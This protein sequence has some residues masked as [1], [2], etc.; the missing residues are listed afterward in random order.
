MLQSASQPTALKDIAS[1]MCYSTVDEAVLASRPTDVRCVIVA[2]AQRE[3]GSA[4]LPP[5]YSEEGGFAD[6]KKV[7]GENPR[8]SARPTVPMG[9]TYNRRLGWYNI[10]MRRTRS[11]YYL[12]LSPTICIS[13]IH[14]HDTPYNATLFPHATGSNCISITSDL[15]F[16]V[17]HATAVTPLCHPPRTCHLPKLL[18]C[19]AS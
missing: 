19:H 10:S 2:L 12:H 14:Q 4:S 6:P 7:Y 11:T 5:W 16:D 3:C 17:T 1:G 13:A 15:P 9:T 18:C 8:H